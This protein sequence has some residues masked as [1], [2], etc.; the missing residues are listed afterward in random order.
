MLNMKIASK[1]SKAKTLQ[2]AD[3]SYANV[4]FT[5]NDCP[6]LKWFFVKSLNIIKKLPAF[7]YIIQIFVNVSNTI[8]H[9][10]HRTV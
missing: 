8:L 10:L 5:I 7:L 6:L 3:M 1:N 9:R 2:R 4:D